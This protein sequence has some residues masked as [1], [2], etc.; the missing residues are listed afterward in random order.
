CQPT[1]MKQHFLTLV[2]LLIIFCLPASATEDR[3][4]LQNA[5]TRASLRTALLPRQDWVPYPAY[6]DRAGWEKLTK[7]FR[8]ELI[9]AGEEYLD[10]EWKVVKLSDYLEFEKSGSRDIMQQPFGDNNNAMMALVLAELAEGKGRF[11]DQIMNGTWMACEMTT[12]VLSAHLSAYQTNKRAIPDPYEFTIDL[13][14]GDLGSFYSWLYYFFRDEFDK[15]SPLIATRLRRNLQERI[16]DVYMN[17]SDFWWQAFDLEPG[18]TVN[19]WNPWCNSNVLLTFLLLED[20]PEK[21]ATGVYRTM[22]STDAFINYT[23]ADGA[24]EEGPSYWG[25]AAGKLFDYL[26]ILHLATGG[27][28]SVFDQPIIKNMGEYIARSYVGGGWVVNFA[29]ASARGGG[30]P[31][32]IFRYGKAVSSTEM[33]QFAAYLFEKGGRKHHVPR[34]RDLFRALE[35]LRFSDELAAI[36]PALPNAAHTWYPETEFCYMRSESGLFFAA[37][38]GYNNE[39][40]NHNDVGSFSLYYDNI[41]FFIDAGVGTYTR[42]TFS[43]ERY[44]IWTMQSNYHNL[45]MINGIEQKNGSDF[46]ASEVSFNPEQQRFSLDIAGAYPK[47]AAVKQ[48]VRTYTLEDDALHIEDNF[49]LREAG[50]ANQ[51]N[52]L[53]WAEPQL[54]ADG[55]VQLMRDGHQLELQYPAKDFTAS[56]ELV[57]LDD[58][59]LSGVWGDQ[60]YR[61]S[62]KTTK[63]D[64][65]GQYRLKIV[66]VQ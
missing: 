34:G 23:H 17:R 61:L 63:P 30:E 7:N 18:E 2:C 35:S 59:R 38:G 14:A 44:S 22:V 54:L 48:W 57:K 41:P 52:F 11:M 50:T 65:K 66:A 15:V 43:S 42:Q 60:I 4:L 20:D 45:P 24:C 47:E 36:Q 53:T 8:Q 32:V 64:T 46:R 21:L 1:P 26:D 33:Q 58:V 9:S 3:D 27:K 37:K 62:L 6:T 31:S 40:H 51:L 12:W 13:T 16:L 39:S 56:V 29:D 10:Y 55:R 49:R 28:V 5:I 25:H 19:N